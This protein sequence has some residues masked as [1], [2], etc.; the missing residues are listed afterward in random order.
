MIKNLPPYSDIQLRQLAEF[1]K[2]GECS[3]GHHTLIS[4]FYRTLI[5]K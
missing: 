1:L 4:Y 2:E 5:K 3:N